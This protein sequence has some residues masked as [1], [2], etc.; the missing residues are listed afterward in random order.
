[1]QGM[2]SRLGVPSSIQRLFPVFLLAVFSMAWANYATLSRGA[3][4]DIPRD[5]DQ[6]EENKLHLSE[7]GESIA[8]SG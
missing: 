2:I 1:M 7:I 8:N 5:R 6:G 4:W 3:S